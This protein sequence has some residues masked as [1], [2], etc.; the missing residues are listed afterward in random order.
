MTPTFTKIA[1]EPKL[2][3]E[4]HPAGD[5]G[6]GAAVVVQASDGGPILAAAKG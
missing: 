4:T 1:S 6:L 2:H 5:A 3:A